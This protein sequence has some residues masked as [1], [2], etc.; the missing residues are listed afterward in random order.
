[1]RCWAYRKGNPNGKVLLLDQQ[2]IFG[3]EAKQNELEVDGY[4]LTAPQ[5]AT[6]IVVPEDCWSPMHIAWERS[7]TGF[8]YEGKGWV[9]NPW[10]DGFKH[11]PISA[12][13]RQAL[14]DMEL[15]RT[16]PRRHRCQFSSR[17]R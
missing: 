17:G 2:P 5:G 6:D 14:V 16:P 12:A 10:R 3:G 15:Y 1:M 13:A 4:H 9:K 11:A 7:D 8:Y